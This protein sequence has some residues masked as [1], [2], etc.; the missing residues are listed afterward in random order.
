M[1]YNARDYLVLHGRIDPTPCKTCGGGKPPE[2][3]SSSDCP[4]CLTAEMV[5]DGCPSE[6]VAAMIA[7]IMGRPIPA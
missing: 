2:F 4:A 5:A 6:A 1:P 3:N 7:R